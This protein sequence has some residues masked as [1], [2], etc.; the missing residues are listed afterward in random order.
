MRLW[1]TMPPKKIAPTILR[2]E[3][4][5]AINEV[6]RTDLV[7]RKTQKVRANQ[8]KLL[9]VFERRLLISKWRKV[10]VGEKVVMGIS[11]W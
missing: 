1:S 9:V 10:L 5:P 7:S 6:V 2:M 4:I 3:K 11:I 8:M